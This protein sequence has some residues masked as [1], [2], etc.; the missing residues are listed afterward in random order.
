M[1]RNNEIIRILF[2]TAIF[3]YSSLATCLRMKAWSSENYLLVFIYFKID[4]GQTWRIK[5]LSH[6]GAK[7]LAFHLPRLTNIDVKAIRKSR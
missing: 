6:H 3:L 2:Y 1:Q 4:A 5:C 7:E